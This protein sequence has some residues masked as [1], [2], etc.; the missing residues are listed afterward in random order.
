MLCVPAPCEA[1]ISTIKGQV[2]RLLNWKS[3]TE[4]R[5]SKN[6]EEMSRFDKA[7]KEH[8]KAMQKTDTQLATS[9]HA[10]SF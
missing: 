7:L 8:T 1:D 3:D 4:K 10:D 5:L 9:C 6:D 2:E